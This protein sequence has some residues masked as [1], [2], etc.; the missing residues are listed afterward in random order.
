MNVYREILKDNIPRL[1]A[2]Y[3]LDR[4]SPSYGYADRP[5]WAWKVSDFANATFQGAAHSLAIA[6]RLGLIENESF[7][8]NVIDSAIRAVERICSK[9]GSLQGAQP[10]T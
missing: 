6:L 4:F 2:L 8:L 7:V 1:L 10:H 3:N 5:Y 9:N